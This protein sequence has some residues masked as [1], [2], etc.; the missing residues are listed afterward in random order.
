ML[1]D[2]ELTLSYIFANML[3]FVGTQLCCIHHALKEFPAQR[4][5]V[6]NAGTK[7]SRRITRVFDTF[8]TTGFPLKTQVRNLFATFKWIF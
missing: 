5:L 2:L 3:S 8:S 4:I 1:H 7:F 6:H